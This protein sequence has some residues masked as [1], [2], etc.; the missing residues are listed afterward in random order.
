MSPKQAEQLLR[1]MAGEKQANQA[2]QN[3]QSSIHI[4]HPPYEW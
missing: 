3:E 4:C 2:V 1:A